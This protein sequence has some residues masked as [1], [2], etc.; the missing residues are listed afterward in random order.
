MFRQE[1][2]DLAHFDLFEHVTIAA[3]CSRDLR[4]SR[5]QRDTIAYEPVNSDILSNTCNYK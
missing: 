5:L 1:F 2:Q 4:K 3:A